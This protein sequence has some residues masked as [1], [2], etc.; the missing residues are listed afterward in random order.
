MTKKRLFIAMP[1]GKRKAPLDM[2]LPD[3]TVEIDFDSVWSGLIRP[4]LPKAYEV[5]RA[6]ELHRPGLIDLMY[7]EWLFEADIVLADLTFGNPNVFYELGIRQA[8]SKKG[9]ILVACEGMRPPFDVRNQ[10]IINYN[11]FAAPSAR[12][13]Q[14]QLREAIRVAESQV[15][16]SPV[17]V[18]LPGLYVTRTKP[19]SHPEEIIASLRSRLSEAE[20]KLVRYVAQANDERLR[21]KLESADSVAR[22][23]S[24]AGQVVDNPDASLVLVEALAIKLRKFGLVDDA[25]S[26][27]EKATA[28]NPNDSELLR[29][30]GFCFRKKGPRFYAQ[31]ETYMREALQL[32]DADVE[33]HGMYGG[34]L[35]RRHAFVDAQ[36]HYQRAHDLDPD[37]LYPLV[38]LGAISAALGRTQDALAWY[39]KVCRVCDE[40]IF[41]DEA[42]YWTHLCRAEALVAAGNGDEAGKALLRA[43]EAGAPIE[44]LR[45]E[46]EQ[47]DFFINIDF[48]ASAAKAA[49]QALSAKAPSVVTMHTSPGTQ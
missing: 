4:A 24:V 36:K 34:L 30:L 26:V 17:H 8:L 12:K 3:K 16:D 33:L 40:V 25:I 47:L 45:S 43:L 46:T 2:D 38:N 28:S 22:I 9:T 18:F 48:A 11:Y 10:S 21:I 7:N 1:Y 15:L 37:N 23:R 19:G 13:F 29:E 6:D 42:D 14:S 32:N 41:K 5:K 35:K 20:S 49:L 39:V 44:D 31:A 27:L